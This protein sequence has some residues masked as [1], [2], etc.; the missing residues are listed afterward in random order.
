MPRSVEGLKEELQRFNR[1]SDSPYEEHQQT[2]AEYERVAEELK[3]LR[4]S[5][6]S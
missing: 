5:R 6:L 2:K 1:T 3:Y 4:G